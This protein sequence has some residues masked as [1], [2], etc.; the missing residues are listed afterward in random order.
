MLVTG[1]SGFIGYAIVR[2]LLQKGARVSVIDIAQLPVYATKAE[3]RSIRFTKGTVTSSPTLAAIIK[4]EKVR[5]IFHLAAEAIVGEA[6][7]DPQKAFD[8]NVRGTWTILELVR[9]RFPDTDVIVASSDKAYGSHAKLPYKED[10]PLFGVNP[11]DASKSAADLVAHSYARTYGLHLSIAR[12]GNVFG[13]GD[14]NWSRLIPDGLRCLFKGKTLRLRSNGA[15]ARD[16]VYIDDI[17][18]AYLALGENTRRK[19][20]HGDAFNFGTNTPMTVRDV[21]TAI[22]KAGGEKLKFSVADTARHEIQ[23]QYLDSSKAKERLHWSAKISRA[24]GMRRTAQWYRDFV[25]KK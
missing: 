10:A 4:K 1:G 23:K 19:K 8:T 16:Y 17:V 20:M 18:E 24:E 5:T 11:Y 21:L 22:E 7:A 2:S 25:D 3:R 15:Y 12:C 14:L 13:P 9:A 6:Y